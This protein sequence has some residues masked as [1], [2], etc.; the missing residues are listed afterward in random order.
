[1]QTGL[2]YDQASNFEA[3]GSLAQG[4]DAQ[5]EDQYSYHYSVLARQVLVEGKLLYRFRERYFPYFL[6]GLGTAFNKASSYGTNVPPFSTFTR[7]YQNNTQTS[8][9]Y[10]IGLGVDVD[11][12]NHLRLGIGYRFADFGQVQLGKSTIDTTSVGGTLTQTHLYANEILAQLTFV[13]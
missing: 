7:Q 2:G 3:K 6:L 9:S 12:I 1:M 4:A 13:I 11:V 10:A 5:S 8:F